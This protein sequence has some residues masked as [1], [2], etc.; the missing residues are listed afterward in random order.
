MNSK[1]RH[2][3]PFGDV[4]RY[5]SILRILTIVVVMTVLLIAPTDALSA[6]ANASV[7]NQN[8]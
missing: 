3:C 5:S 6:E 7:L 8:S 4:P 2:N 1:N